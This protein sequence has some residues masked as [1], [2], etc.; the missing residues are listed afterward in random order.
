MKMSDVEKKKD[1]LIGGDNAEQ[2]KI[3]RDMIVETKICE[4]SEMLTQTIKVTLE[5]NGPGPTM[6]PYRT[7]VQIEL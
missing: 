2:I 5:L 3:L 6:R 1:I 4:K 7:S